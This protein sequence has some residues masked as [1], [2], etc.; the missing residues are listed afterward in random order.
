MAFH[1]IF[2]ENKTPKD[3]DIT[4]WLLQV[5]KAKHYIIIS[6]LKVRTHNIIMWLIPTSW[7]IAFIQMMDEYID[8]VLK[9]FAFIIN[10]IVMHQYT[11][12]FDITYVKE[13]CVDHDIL[14]TKHF[15]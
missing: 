4:R 12:V 1:Y 15:P 6:L 9:S 11:K 3:D 8:V 14:S 7:E 10:H 5:M 2:E 13:C